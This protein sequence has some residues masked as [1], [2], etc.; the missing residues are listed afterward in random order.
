MPWPLPLLDGGQHFLLLLIEGV[1]GSPP[2]PAACKM[3][4]MQSGFLLL[5]G[6]S[7]VLIVKDTSQLSWCSS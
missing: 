7:A 5:V 1:R 6:L 3:V 4:F 2:A